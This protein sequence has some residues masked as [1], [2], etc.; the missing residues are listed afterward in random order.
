[1]ELLETLYCLQFFDE[2]LRFKSNF[3]SELGWEIHQRY[4]NET[5]SKRLFAVS[6]DLP[7]KL[8]QLLDEIDESVVSGSFSSTL[9][10]PL[11]HY[12]FQKYSL[13]ELAR[14][15]SPS[16]QPA[17]SVELTQ[18]PGL[19][20][21]S[22]LKTLPLL[23]SSPAPVASTISTSSSTTTPQS[24]PISSSPSLSKP[25]P[26]SPKPPTAKL[27]P[28]PTDR[29][30]DKERTEKEKTTLDALVSPRLPQ[31]PPVV[32]KPLPLP[33]LPVTPPPIPTIPLGTAQAFQSGACPDP[34]TPRS[35]QQ[36]VLQQQQRERAE[37]E[38]LLSSGGK[39][40]TG[41]EQLA[42]TNAPSSQP[43]I[44]RSRLFRSGTDPTL[45]NH[46]QQQ[47]GDNARGTSLII[48][49]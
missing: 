32:G 15:L 7:A 30:P 39:E 31:L 9:F 34:T 12:L 27:H 17:L 29:A 41:G 3:S 8:L 5:G 49:D 10:D 19:S 42:P 38:Q 37:R 20:D 4:L 26:V 24:A 6:S 25:L 23:P 43:G 13:F 33:S 2:T 45:P 28:A 21:I 44:A 40:A 14:L 35:L 46:M 18:S 16:P 1:M 48:N 36:Q 47:Q 22:A 11:L